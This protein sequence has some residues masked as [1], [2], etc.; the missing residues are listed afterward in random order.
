MDQ[1]AQ[2]S[3]Q[4]P[5]WFWLLGS[6]LAY[7]AGEFSNSAILSKMKL[8]TRGRYLWTRTIGSTIVGEGL[9]TVIFCMVA[10]YGTLPGQVLWAVILSNY[11][12]KCGVEICLTPMTYAIVR[13]LKRRENIDTFDHGIRY[14]PFTLSL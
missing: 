1:L 14:N 5:L 9:D 6:L 12:F 7:F 11:V 10:F 4:S 3:T 8:L 2:I 13:T